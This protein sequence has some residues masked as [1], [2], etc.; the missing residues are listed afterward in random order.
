M[1]FR[2][3]LGSYSGRSVPANQLGD[4]IPRKQR[5]QK[6]RLGF[7]GPEPENLTL[8]IRALG[9]GLRVTVIGIYRLIRGQLHRVK[10]TEA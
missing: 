7:R 3:G 4:A 9:L 10:A 6:V 8:L 5:P 1:D 2:P